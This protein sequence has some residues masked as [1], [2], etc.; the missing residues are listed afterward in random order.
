MPLR[1]VM[2]MIVLAGL[3]PAAAMALGLGDIHLKSALNARL[4]AEIVDDNNVDVK[5][6]GVSA[7]TLDIG[8][9]GSTLNVARKTN[10]TIDGQKVAR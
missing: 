5:T 2:R 6:S 10:V 4:D 7:F 8:P 1:Y 3:L 9:G